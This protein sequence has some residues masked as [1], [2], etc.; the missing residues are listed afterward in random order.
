MT[1]TVDAPIYSHEHGG[2]L[3]SKAARLQ[4]ILQD[5]NP[6]ISLVFIPPKNRS[7]ED[8]HP[9]ALL[10]SSPWRAPY[11]IRHI[12]EVEIEDP[13]KIL[14]WL[15][16]GDLSKHSHVSIMAKQKI[17]EEAAKLVDLKRQEDDRL[18][19]QDLAASLLVG[20]RDHKNYYRHNGKVFRQ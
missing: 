8:T 5:Y 18:E 6:Y 20:G 2:F 11:I 14:A 1:S 4:E 13:A 10:D 3:S 9:Y 16:E 17:A 7:A 12:T 19:R 15:F